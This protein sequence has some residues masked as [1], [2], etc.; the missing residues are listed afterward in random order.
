MSNG[1]HYTAR[2]V[3]VWTRGNVHCTDFAF[4]TEGVQ[5]SLLEVNEAQSISAKEAVLDPDTPVNQIFRYTLAD[6]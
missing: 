6:Y 2:I 1:E 4:V 3:L 5:P